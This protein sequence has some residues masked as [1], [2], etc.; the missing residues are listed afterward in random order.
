MVVALRCLLAELLLG[1]F[2]PLL[3]LLWWLR[4]LLG[5]LLLGLLLALLGLLLVLGPLG[6]L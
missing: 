1:L 3:V 6:W 4:L 5:R 2:G